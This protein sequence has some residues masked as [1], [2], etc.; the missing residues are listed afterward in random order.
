MM[1]LPVIIIAHEPIIRDN[2]RLWL[3]DKPLKHT[4]PYVRLYSLI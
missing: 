1:L 2:Q 4:H 3:A